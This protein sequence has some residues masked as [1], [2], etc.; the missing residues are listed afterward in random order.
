MAL[1]TLFLEMLYCITNT[2]LHYCK[3][4]LQLVIL[5][6]LSMNSYSLS[7]IRIYIS[8]NANNYYN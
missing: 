2:A 7:R 1:P 3:I 8:R 4:L 5:W 6:V